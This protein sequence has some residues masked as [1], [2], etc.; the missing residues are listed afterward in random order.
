[1]QAKVVF[2]QSNPNTSNSSITQQ[3]KILEKFMK[4]GAEARRGRS[5]T[6]MSRGRL[7]AEV[8]AR[9]EQAAKGRKKQY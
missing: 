7:T 5:C 9:G 3:D 2:H 4:T 1:M 8:E 6:C